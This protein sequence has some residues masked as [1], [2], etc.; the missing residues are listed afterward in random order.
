M[1]R[2]RRE[3]STILVIFAV[4][5]AL[6]L[7]L[8]GQTPETLKASYDDNGQLIKVVDPNGNVT[9]YAY[10]VIGNML[11]ITTTSVGGGSSLAI[12]NFT[13][14]QG[15]IGT[16]VTIQGQNFSTTPSADIVKFNGTATTVTAAT[17]STLTV[18]VP[19]GATTGPISVTVGSATATTT[20]NFTVLQNP[21]IAS[22]NPTSALQGGTVSNFQ[23][24]GL[25]LGNATFSFVP[26]F[27]PAAI[28]ASN[29]SI[30]PDGTSATMTLT[31][32]AN[33]VG[34]FALVAT[35]AAGSSSQVA[36]ANNTLT[37]LSTN[38][39][40]DADGDGL[41]NLYEEAI[42]SNPLNPSTAG[43]TI[44]DG[45][46]LFFGL[47]PSDASGGNCGLCDGSDMEVSG[48]TLELGFPVHHGADPSW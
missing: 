44:P 18:T 36:G 22:V 28:S 1:L 14:E 5:V 40:A 20:N 26:A 24:T 47:N 48:W 39:S 6:P 3:L 23:V 19:T 29:V 12:F 17:S 32:A 8:S 25:N 11:S 7:G 15:G 31:L 41:T 42:T 33:A 21:E 16:T 10:D 35:T 43:D 45:W 2:L 38:P 46:A 9:T 30:S 37:V 4:I 13:P 27:V 34:S